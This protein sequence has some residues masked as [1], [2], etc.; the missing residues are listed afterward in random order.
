[1]KLIG[2]VPVP[3]ELLFQWRMQMLELRWAFVRSGPGRGFL[4]RE[5]IRMRA[6]GEEGLDRLAGRMQAM[7]CFKQRE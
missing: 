6:E 3:A 4:G 1:M 2:T 7:E 5:A